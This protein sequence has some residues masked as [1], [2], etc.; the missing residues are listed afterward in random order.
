MPLPGTL[1]SPA[2]LLSDSFSDPAMMILGFSN[3]LFYLLSGVLIHHLLV[4]CLPQSCQIQ[5]KL[6][7][8]P[9]GSQSTLN[10]ST[11]YLALIVT[12]NQHPN[13]TTAFI[14]PLK[15][16]IVFYGL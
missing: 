16:L 11:S 3:D 12:L 4:D 10:F 9:V 5:P 2:L 6:V 15:L 13:F 14:T 8:C 1:Q 7:A